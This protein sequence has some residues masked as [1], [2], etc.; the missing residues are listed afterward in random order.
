VEFLNP[1]LKAALIGVKLLKTITDCTNVI[2]SLYNDILRLAP[3]YTPQYFAHQLHKTHK[4]SDTIDI[5]TG[6]LEYTPLKSIKQKW[7]IKQKP[8]L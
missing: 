3:K 8:L 4:D 5:N 7:C 6:T 2:N 1:K